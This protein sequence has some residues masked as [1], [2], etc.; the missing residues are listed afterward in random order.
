MHFAGR[1]V[2]QREYDNQEL[3]RLAGE[4]HSSFSS[5]MDGQ[6]DKDIVYSECT[7]WWQCYCVTGWLLMYQVRLAAGWDLARLQ[8]AATSSRTL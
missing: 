4:T 3:L 5:W 7:V 6:M 2:E 1:Q 8:V